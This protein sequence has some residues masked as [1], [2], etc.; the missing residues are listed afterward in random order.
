MSF[1][2]PKMIIS[3]SL[4]TI[5]F[6]FINLFKIIFTVVDMV[7]TKYHFFYQPPLYYIS[8]ANIFTKI[9][10]GSPPG[11]NYPVDQWCFFPVNP[12][13][14]TMTSDALTAVIH[15]PTDT[16]HI[17]WNALM[18]QFNTL[19]L[20]QNSWNFAEHILKC[21]PWM[22]ITWFLF[23]F[24]LSFFYLSVNKKHWFK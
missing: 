23:Y 7:R 2:V 6:F 15:R 5:F 3:I 12:H 20:E 11:H 21:I 1:S 19:R 22:K 8:N 9:L 16:A 24:P 13:M 17:P 10:S 4:K 18:A 14:D